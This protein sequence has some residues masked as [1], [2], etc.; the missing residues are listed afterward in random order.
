MKR[1]VFEFHGTVTPK[2]GDPFVQSFYVVAVD[3]TEGKQLLDNSN[4]KVP[5]MVY[6]GT[7]HMCNKDWDV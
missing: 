6:T 3:E 5:D 2:E 7:K 4:P 1:Y